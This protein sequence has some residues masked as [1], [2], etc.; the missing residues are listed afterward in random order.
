M[1]SYTLNLPLCPG[2]VKFLPPL[3]NGM[4]EINVE[5]TD[6]Y[7]QKEG[8]SKVGNMEGYDGVSTRNSVTT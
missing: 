7:F 2:L 1:L 6:L 5:D 4:K 8:I 3:F